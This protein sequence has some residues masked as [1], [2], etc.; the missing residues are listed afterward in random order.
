MAGAQGSCPNWPDRRRNGMIGKA[1]MYE[2]LVTVRRVLSTATV[3]FCLSGGAAA[4]GESSDQACEFIVARAVV[5]DKLPDALAASTIEFLH[6]RDSVQARVWVFF[7][8]KGFTDN[9]G[10]VSAASNVT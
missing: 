9:V 8:D 7:T 5:R 3:L 10:F 4:I 2:L 1:L 6:Y